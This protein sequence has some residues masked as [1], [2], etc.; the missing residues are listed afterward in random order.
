MKFNREHVRWFLLGVILFLILVILLNIAKPVRYILAVVSFFIVFLISFVF[1]YKLIRE[2]DYILRDSKQSY[3]KKISFVIPVYNEG[4]NIKDCLNSI[5]N[6][7]YPKDMFEI[8][9]VDDGSND[10]I[11]RK[12]L[13]EYATKYSN[14]KVITKENGGAASAKNIGVLNAT[15]EIII[16]IDSDSI[17][18]K[19]APARLVSYFEDPKVGGVSGSVRALPENSSLNK[20]QS[21]EYDIILVYRRILEAFDSVYV[22]PGGLS[23]F[24]RE[25][26]IKVGLFDINSLTED[27][28]IAINLQKNGYKVLSTLDAFAYT[29]V[30]RDIKTLIKQRIR[31]I[32]GGIW[33]RI[34]H[35]D[36]LNPK[37][38]NIFIFGYLL[39]V[40]F[41][42]PFSTF[43]LSLLL[44]FF[45]WNLWF[46]RLGF[47]LIEL[48][49]D[50][51]M[52]S[53][54]VFWI[55]LLP[56][57]IL[58]INILRD[59]AKMQKVRIGEIIDFIGFMIMFGWAWFLV[60][61][62]VIYKEI[63]SQT[64]RWETR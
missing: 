45:D 29:K 22:T 55:I 19:D 64:N 54:F 15:G 59:K 8:V 6:I 10:D 14:I 12:I 36:L 13:H 2:R 37:W 35:Q 44:I 38:G 63:T 7:N 30:P 20:W 58:M 24:R 31:W 9:V 32:R 17:I 57:Q 23:A 50:H 25:A 43:F 4:E 26:I 40:L 11:T 28:E 21:I 39:D 1:I 27:Q 18:D 56:W 51:F 49:I 47:D 33:N 48:S 42:I 60:W 41:F 3:N 61:P 52:I 46:F 53:T 16:T 34:K 5:L 62:F